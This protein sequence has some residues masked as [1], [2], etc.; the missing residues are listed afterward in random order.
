MTS[1]YILVVAVLLLGGIIAALGDKL[2]S[3]VG[4]AKLR[5]FN[6]RP[7]QTAVVLTVLTGILI[8]ASSLIVLFSAS[9]SLREG[10][11]KLDDILK[12]LRTAQSDLERADVEKL[13]IEKR[14]KDARVKQRQVQ[15]RS[16]EIDANYNRALNKLK[17]V[18]I[19][20][21]KLQTDVQ[22]L[23]KERQQLVS[24]KQDLLLEMS[25]LQEQVKLRDHELSKRQQKIAQQDRILSQSQQV[26]TQSQQKLVQSQQLLAERQERLQIL[27]QRFQ[28]L[29]NQRQQL[30]TDINQ[31]DARIDQLDKAI[32]SQDR[33]I[34]LRENK[35]KDL[36]NQLTFLN[37]EVQV[38]EQYY[39]NYQEL[40]ERRIALL[41]GQVLS[42]GAVRILEPK[43]VN[44]AIDQL[45]REANKA[46]IQAT[47][48][49]N[50]PIPKE[51]IVNITK[52]QVDQLTEQLQDGNDYVVRI[53]SAGNYVQ[54]EN[55]IRVFAD[56]AP[57]KL[58]FRE[59]ESIATVS[60][61]SS[62]FTEEDIQKRLDL[63]LSAAQFRARREGVLGGIQLEDGRVK[64]LIKFIEEVGTANQRPDEIRVEAAN[65]TF[66]LGP[67]KLRMIAIKNGEIVF[68]S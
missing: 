51:P 8:S 36:E 14:L 53:I 15:Q 54:G 6:L 62:T 68:G 31:R 52:A 60:M 29:E 61:E 25:K 28:T 67:L 35:L 39:Q 11:F 5:I 4:K 21:K 13:D 57:N 66:T 12:Q 41:R 19:D 37:R 2:G 1:A 30:Q 58:V 26:L 45:L 16:K 65:E 56:V 17:K 32:A 22:I 7:R 20:A 55:D 40:R 38:L 44:N 50:Q 18:S 3:K 48:P 47:R 10:V 49:P 63:L 46:A 34:K 33:N 64:T 27:A 59:G 43:A 9:K 42:V 23:L 24:Q